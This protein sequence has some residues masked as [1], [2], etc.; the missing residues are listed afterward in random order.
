MD[1]AFG[2]GNDGR[3]DLPFMT[4]KVLSVFNLCFICD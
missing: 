2:T 3:I 4:Y 1:S